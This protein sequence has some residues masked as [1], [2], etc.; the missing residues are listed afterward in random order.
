[1]KIGHNDPCP[2]GSGKKY[3]KCCLGELPP[4]A[5]EPYILSKKRLIEKETGNKVILESR[6]DISSDALIDFP[7]WSDKSNLPKI[8]HKPSIDNVH[9]L[10]ELIHLEKFFVNK[11]SIIAC[12]NTNLHPIIAKFK[13]IPEDY[14]AHKEINHEYDPN[15]IKKSWFPGKDNLTLPDNQVAANLV[16]YHA[17]CEFCPEFKD[18]LNSF[19]KNCEE[20]QPRAFSMAD[21]AIKALEK[22]D[23]QDRDSYN[24]CADEIIKIFAPEY[25]RKKIYTFLTFLKIRTNGNGI[26]KRTP[27]I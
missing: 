21:K 15:P 1:M 16:N 13:N 5:M 18:T 25:H 23:Y 10:H 14:V 3:K 12:N 19:A 6:S 7:G 27:L 9:I 22:M 2:C 4:V 20:Q 8:F 26:F 11:Y 17:F 24:Q